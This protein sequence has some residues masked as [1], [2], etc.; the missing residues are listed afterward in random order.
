MEWNQKILIDAT[1][2]SNF[3]WVNYAII[4][5]SAIALSVAN[6]LIDMSMLS[7]R[8]LPFDSIKEI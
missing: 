7:E 2:G 3:K 5:K 1:A 4:D 6:R 8:V